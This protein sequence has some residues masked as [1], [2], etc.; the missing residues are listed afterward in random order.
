MTATTSSSTTVKN[1]A[2]SAT[3]GSAAG[4]YVYDGNGRRVQK[5]LPTCGGSN[6]NTVYVFSGSKVIAEYDNGALVGSPSREYIYS[7]AA[8][9]AR[10]DS[11]GT[12]YYHQDHLSNRLV[13][14]SSGGVLEQLG[15]FPYG[16]QWYNATGDKLYFTTYER[17]S[18]S[19]NDYAQARYSNSRTGRFNSP[20]PITGSTSDP[21]SL[22]RYSYVRNLPVMLTDPAGLTPQCNTVK[23]D[24]TQP[25]RDTGGGPAVT[26][27]D[28][29]LGESDPG[30]PQQGPGCG[31]IPPWY[32]TIGG[33]GDGGGGAGGF[34]PGGIGSSPGSGYSFGDG[35]ISA[36]IGGGIDGGLGS[37]GDPF[38]GPFGPPDPCF[39]D[40]DG[41]LAAMGM[42][43]GG[44]GQSG[45][46][47]DIKALDICIKLLFGVTL[48][49]FL[50]VEAGVPSTG[51]FTGYMAGV[52]QGYGKPLAAGPSQVMVL[53]DGSMDAS[54][55]TAIFNFSI[56][57]SNLENEEHHQQ[58]APGGIAGFT[59]VVPPFSNVVAYDLPD[60]VGTQ[61]WELGNS[62]SLITG[63][64][65]QP[66][67]HQGGLE[68]VATEAGGKLSN[69]Y[70][71]LRRK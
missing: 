13:T 71:F 26:E 17:D 40:A 29:D 55:V 19:G 59:K 41:S 47:T 43:G 25:D 3:N 7:G 70:D 9:L 18:E 64:Q 54:N 56:A 44:A 12:R 42:C 27:S 10:V 51:L 31:S 1:R 61:I 62:L 30:A 68:N 38:A 48:E 35:G 14:N 15:T 46:G 66:P 16:E 6:P 65:M 36:F 24:E 63:Q 57:F 23:N 58:A 52:N 69:C 37:M 67:G 2:V 34:G 5:C 33:G 53:T 50:E 4:A 21:Q 28:S 11:S 32:Y 20:D 45:G 39:G 22:N 8:L 49:S 60:A